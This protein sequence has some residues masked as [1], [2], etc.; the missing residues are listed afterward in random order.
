M[1]HRARGGGGSSRKVCHS[2]YWKITVGEVVG[3]G[4]R[5]G[6]EYAVKNM[7]FTNTCGIFYLA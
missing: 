5:A 6:E 2:V 7:Q 3:R 4:G 1:S